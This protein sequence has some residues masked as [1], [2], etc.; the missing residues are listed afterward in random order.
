MTFPGGGV[1][2]YYDKK[3][4]FAFRLSVGFY[5]RKW[6]FVDNVWSNG[7]PMAKLPEQSIGLWQSL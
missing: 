5:E 4:L 1:I 6:A 7:V 3:I 2:F